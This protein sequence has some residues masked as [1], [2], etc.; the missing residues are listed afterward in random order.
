M[1]GLVA[2]IS[3]F[4]IHKLEASLV[5]SVRSVLLLF[6]FFKVNL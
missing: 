3:N 4:G 1:A 6:F 2:H 5:Y